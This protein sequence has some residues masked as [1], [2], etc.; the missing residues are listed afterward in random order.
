MKYLVRFLFSSIA[1]AAGVAVAVL[2]ARGPASDS[3]G[4][5]SPVELPAPIATEQVPSHVAADTEAEIDPVAKMPAVAKREPTKPR[6][7]E[8][9]LL[10]TRV[11]EQPPADSRLFEEQT[12]PVEV[13]TD[14]PA[15]PSTISLVQPRTVSVTN[16]A[17]DQPEHA[18]YQDPYGQQA[19]GTLNPQE[20]LSN[21]PPG[22]RAMAAQ[23]GE[24]LL[25]KL[26][27]SGS[28]ANGNQ[29]PSGGSGLGGGLGG[30]LQI[31]G[32]DLGQLPA[33]LPGAAPPAEGAPDANDPP[34]PQITIRK[35]PRK[36][37]SGD[38]STPGLAEIP[39][40][41]G[42]EHLEIFVQDKDIREVL[43][44]LSEAGGLNI[45]AS[46]SVSGT[47]SANLR[48]VSIDQALD[49]I[50]K[51]TGYV[52]RR[53]GQFIYVG[54]S[55]DFSELRQSL[56][57][58]GTRI[59]RPNYSTAAELQTLII[60]LLTPETGKSSI[61]TPAQ[62]GIPSDG[63]AAGGDS[64]SAGEALLVQDFEA[65]LMQV[66][67]IVAEIDKR[68]MQVAI[69]A[70]ILSVKLDDTNQFGVD[71]Q[72]LREQGTLRLGLGSPGSDLGSVNF[73]DG[74]L[75]FAFLDSNLGAFLQALETV[76][77]TSVITT[78][79]LM[80]LN[81]QRAEILIGEQ[82]GYVSTTVTETSTAQSVE[83]LEVGA[84]LRIR[85][86]ISPDGIIRMEIHPELSTGRVD[87]RG[88]FTLPEKSVT[89]VTT[90]IMVR[91]GYT[92]VIG[93][94]MSDELTSTVRQVPIMGNLPVI[95][96]LFRLTTEQ[97]ER[98]ELLVLVTPRIM[99]D[100]DGDN[101]GVEQAGEFHRRHAIYAD[102][103]LPW[104]KRYQA[105]HHFR[106]AQEA[107]QLGRKDQA[108]RHV[109][110]SIQIDPLNR[111]AQDLRSDITHG[112]HFGEHSA[113]PGTLLEA[114]ES[115]LDGPE[116]DPRILERLEQ[117]P[118]AK[119]SGPRTSG[120]VTQRHPLPK[121]RKK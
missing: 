117:A 3:P 98:R 71:F 59:Y 32:L 105:R 81:K 80:A 73:G 7:P 93:G 43:N 31:P 16:E 91:D 72:F 57:S 28:K 97:N 52:A 48:G 6:L 61:T 86:F 12:R 101:E 110:M 42:D 75:K 82:L 17:A 76:G 67:Q 103:T 26:L 45:L 44:L 23:A 38:A 114:A 115:Y 99:N 15:S 55:Q 95:G 64:F 119:S 69:E 35:M 47:V 5:L 50:L 68:P 63:E 24:Q 77:E 14:A 96:P 118:T 39:V 8:P 4:A 13:E 49:A 78:P 37:T 10:E 9:S 34:A 70:M 21:L 29:A 56:D 121:T 89:Q 87:V 40:V 113:P 51:S 66:D 60:P 1:C 41:E 62:T 25:N 94:L 90:N 100:F 116:L 46:R 112:I 11:A 19:G 30:L 22:A 2:V 120:R 109:N 92:V 104:G 33:A 36:R 107:W 65:V 106:L 18:P 83:F 53:E 54:T 84:Q 27:N 58:I 85:P 102:K 111:A 20:I 88:G 74:G 79:R 108:L